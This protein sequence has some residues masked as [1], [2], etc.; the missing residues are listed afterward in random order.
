MEIL[1]ISIG[2]LIVG[3]KALGLGL[4]IFIPCWLLARLGKGYKRWERTQRESA[5]SIRL[6]P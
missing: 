4:A 1:G 3:G 2:A 5:W 6:I